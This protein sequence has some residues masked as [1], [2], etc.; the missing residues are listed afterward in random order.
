MGSVFAEWKLWHFVLG[1]L[2]LDADFVVQL[3]DDVRGRV[4]GHAYAMK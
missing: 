4:L 3:L 2:R 1:S